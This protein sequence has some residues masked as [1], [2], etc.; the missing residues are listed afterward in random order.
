MNCF[1]QYMF[2]IN[3]PIL[4][5]LFIKF[6]FDLKEFPVFNNYFKSYQEKQDELYFNFEFTFEFEC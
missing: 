5:I 2:H 3:L 4:Y 1:Q 6:N